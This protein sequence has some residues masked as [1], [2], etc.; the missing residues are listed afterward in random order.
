M[1]ISAFILYIIMGFTAGSIGVY[2]TF[3]LAGILVGYLI[4]GD[5]RKFIVSPVLSGLIDS[6]ILFIIGYGAIGRGLGVIG[7]IKAPISTE[8]WQQSEVLPDFL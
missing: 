2:L 8:F 3:I 5:I 4:S 1:L 7:A 6:N